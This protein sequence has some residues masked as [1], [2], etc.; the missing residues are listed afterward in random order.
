MYHRLNRYFIQY[1]TSLF[2]VGISIALLPAM[3]I[4]ISNWQGRISPVFDVSQELLL[5]DFEADCILN[6]KHI[7]LGYGNP[8]TRTEQMVALGIGMLI[9]GAIS[10]EH[11]NILRREGIQVIAFTCGRVDGILDALIR[12]CLDDRQ[13]RMPGFNAPTTVARGRFGKGRRHDR[14]KGKTPLQEKRP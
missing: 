1:D 8:F 6:K 2:D 13:F 9:C 4:A 12:D 11:E 14:R 3:K 7:L 10:K 5:F